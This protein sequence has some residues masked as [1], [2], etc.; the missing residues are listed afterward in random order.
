MAS[1]SRTFSIDD[2]L[3]RIRAAN[4]DVAVA[5]HPMLT[6]LV[7][8][9][10]GALQSA[11]VSRETEPATHLTMPTSRSDEHEPR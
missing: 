11:V 9:T 6:R 1:S 2:L 8:G 10:L 4:V 7:G 5:Q 3:A